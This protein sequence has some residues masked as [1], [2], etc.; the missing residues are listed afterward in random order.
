MFWL[1]PTLINCNFDCHCDCHCHRHYHR[2][3]HRIWYMNCNPNLGGPW[4]TALQI[5]TYSICNLLSQLGAH[6]RVVPYLQVSI[7]AVS[8]SARAVI[9]ST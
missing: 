9:Q 5:S 7:R 3:C 4:E 6:K 2:H 1:A 8:L